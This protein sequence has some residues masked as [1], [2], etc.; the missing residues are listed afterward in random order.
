M[1]ITCELPV[2]PE[3]EGILA[4]LIRVEIANGND[5]IAER[6]MI[7]GLEEV[8]TAGYPFNM[9]YILASAALLLA[10]Q[11]DIEK[12]LEVYSLVHSWAFVS[13]S[14]WFSDVY[15]E[16]LLS[17]CG[18]EEIIV[19]ERQP[20]EILWQMAESLLAEARQA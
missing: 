13:N 14:V 5:Q 8:I 19:K 9:L 3:L 6:L 17:L 16:P 7:E 1:D 12:A 2:K 15:K 4:A 10:V 20:K 18:T 11:G